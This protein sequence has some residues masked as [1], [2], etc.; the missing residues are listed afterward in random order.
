MQTHFLVDKDTTDIVALPIAFVT[1]TDET[2][3]SSDLAQFKAKCNPSWG[4]DDAKMTTVFNQVMDIV[5]PP[6]TPA[7]AP[8]KNATSNNNS[9]STGSNP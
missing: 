7:T 1:D 5:N 8:K 3:C 6:T 2:S 9:S 4:W